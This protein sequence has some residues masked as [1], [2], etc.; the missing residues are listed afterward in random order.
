MVKAIVFDFDGVL[1]DTEPLH[2]RAFVE[3]VRHLGVDFDYARYMERYV[4]FDDRDGFRAIGRDFNVAIAESDLPV[5]IASKAHIFEQVVAEGVQPIPGT[6]ELAE[7]AS[8]V[9][10]VGL[11]SGATAHDIDLILPRLGQKG[12]AGVFTARVTADDVSHSKPD[13]MSYRLV[14]HRLGLLPGDCVAIEDTP[15]GIESAK[16]AGLRVVGLAGGFDRKALGR[17]DRVVESL[18]GVGPDEFLAWFA[19]G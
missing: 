9:V 13:P 6:V 17:A 12:L 19:T 8:R 1:V 5:L 18:Q 3:S 7:G 16:G 4:G 15:A 14:C 2:Y 11:C 10:P